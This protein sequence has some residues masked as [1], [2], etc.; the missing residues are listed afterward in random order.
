MPIP[1]RGG[2]GLPGALPHEVAPVFKGV[3]LLDRLP[4]SRVMRS[5]VT[6]RSR[7]PA[8]TVT[9][10]KREAEQATSTTLSRAGN[11]PTTVIFLPRSEMFPPVAPSAF[12]YAWRYC[13]MKLPE[14]L[15]PK[16]R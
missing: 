10:L 6:G 15:N 14:H 2:S 7:R 4:T 16:P 8:D 5:S 3:F 12:I 11:G 13:R 9:L 1:S